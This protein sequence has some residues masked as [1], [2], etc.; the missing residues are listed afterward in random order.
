M[1]NS[2]ET[3]AVVDLASKIQPVEIS[4]EKHVKRVALPPQWTLTEK[5]DEALL[6]VPNRKHGTIQLDDVDS[7]IKYIT[8][9]IIKDQ[10]TIYCIADY[11]EG[12]VSFRAVINDHNGNPDGQQWRDYVALYTPKASVE[13]AR[14]LISNKQPFSQFDFAMFIEDN[15]ADIAA[16][17]GMPTGQQLLEMAL[18]FQASQDMKYKSAIRLQNGGVNMSF[19]QDDDNQTLMNMKMF[20]KIAIGIPAFWNGDA[21]RIDARLRYRVKEGTLRFWYELIR[22]DKVLQDAAETLIIKIKAETGVDL[23][24]GKP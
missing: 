8:R 1:E 19:V 7:F 14:W 22:E 5:N 24:F 6:Q 3:Q 18:S 12:K 16:V 17:E 13:W 20:E 15:L 9:H 10:T 2:S 21:Y 4:N 11:A 23:Y